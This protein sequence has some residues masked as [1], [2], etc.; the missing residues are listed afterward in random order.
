[1]STNSTGRI[2]SAEAAAVR[3]T[4]TPPIPIDCRKRSGNTV[5]ELIATATVTAL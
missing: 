5:S 4:S 2:V 3:A 1:M